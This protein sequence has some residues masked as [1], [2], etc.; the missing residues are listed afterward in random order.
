MIVDTQALARE[1]FQTQLTQ[2][3]RAILKDEPTILYD[4]RFEAM[5]ISPAAILE[6]AC[7]LIERQ[8]N[9]PLSSSPR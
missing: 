8:A 4:G 1:Q 7:S 3:R 9:T 6:V 2:L 5:I